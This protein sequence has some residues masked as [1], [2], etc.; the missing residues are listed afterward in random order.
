MYNTYLLSPCGVVAPSVSYTPI[1]G[2][3]EGTMAES[4]LP[5]SLKT[6]RFKWSI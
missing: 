1:E 6:E 5:I 4:L 2:A 3:L